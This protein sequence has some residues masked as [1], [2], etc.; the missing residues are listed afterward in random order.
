MGIVA[1]Q[2]KHLDG[3]SLIALVVI[4]K[5]HH[6]YY[7]ESYS[8]PLLRMS[9]CEGSSITRDTVVVS[10]RNDD[11]FYETETALVVQMYDRN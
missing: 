6:G 5:S 7:R 11:P 3:R 8:L 2:Q 9:V 10:C 1:E 4:P